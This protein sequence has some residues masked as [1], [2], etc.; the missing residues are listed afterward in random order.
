VLFYS[1]KLFTN[2]VEELERRQKKKWAIN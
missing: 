1:D 2:C